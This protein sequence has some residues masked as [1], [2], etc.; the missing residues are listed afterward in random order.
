MKDLFYQEYKIVQDKIEVSEE[1]QDRN[2]GPQL[3]G[4]ISDVHTIYSH[5]KLLNSLYPD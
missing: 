2:S 5:N 1:I 3:D 4:V